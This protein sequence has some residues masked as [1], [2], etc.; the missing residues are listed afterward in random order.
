MHGEG[1]AQTTN[2]ADCGMQIS[3]CGFEKNLD[4]SF[5][6]HIPQSEIQN[7][8]VAAKAVVVRKSVDRKVVRVQVPPSA[9]KVS[10]VFL[11]IEGKPHFYW[12]FAHPMFCI[13]C[14]DHTFRL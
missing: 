14:T 13:V 11:L 4:L 1:I 2:P 7:R 12:L 9:S 3:D 10:A 5:S 8:V 6:I